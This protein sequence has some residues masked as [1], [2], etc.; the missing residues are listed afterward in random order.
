MRGGAPLAIAVRTAWSLSTLHEQM[1]IETAQPVDR[2]RYK[3]KGNDRYQNRDRLATLDR[4]PANIEWPESKENIIFILWKQKDISR[5]LTHDHFC[6]PTR[7][8]IPVQTTRSPRRAST[9]VP[10]T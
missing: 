8:K 10:P 9:D 6:R 3:A 4:R 7:Y 5:K 2:P 1:I